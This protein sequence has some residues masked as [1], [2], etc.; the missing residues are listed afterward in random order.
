MDNFPSGAAMARWDMI[1]S[2]NANRVTDTPVSD[3]GRIR[4]LR[5][6]VLLFGA[7][8]RCDAVIDAA[9]A[10]FKP[11]VITWRRAERLVLLPHDA[12]GTLILRGIDALDPIDQQ[13]LFDWLSASR[14]PRVISTAAVSLLDRLERG[15][16]LSSLYY[17]LNTVCIVGDGHA[18][19]RLRRL[20]RTA[21][22]ADVGSARAMPR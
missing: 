15:V 11:P 22:K 16:F 1:I 3:A 17:R 6:N 20:V 4:H 13:R 2:R 10:H 14:A 7:D 18:E 9:R 8:T 21:P 12:V 19:R 5:A